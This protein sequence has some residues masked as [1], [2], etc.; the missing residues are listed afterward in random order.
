MTSKCGKDTSDTR[1]FL[2]VCHFFCC[3]H[4]STPSVIY[5]WTDAQ[6]HGIFLLNSRTHLKVMRHGHIWT[7]K[8]RCVLI[9]T[10]LF[11]NN[12]RD[13]CSG[14]IKWMHNS[15]HVKAKGKS[16][17]SAFLTVKNKL[18]SVFHAPVLLLTVSLVLSC[19]SSLDLLRIPRS[20]VKRTD[21]VAKTNFYKLVEVNNSFQKH[22]LKKC[23]F[24]CEFLLKTVQRLTGLR[25][26]AAPSYKQP[27]KLSQLQKNAIEFT[28]S[29]FPCRLK[30]NRDK[31]ATI[32]RLWKCKRAKEWPSPLTGPRN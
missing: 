4:I 26:I 1:G 12:C 29:D 20:E 17:Q 11:C 31:L 13:F 6:Q 19:Q 16:W 5:Y 23:F 9:E 22:S 30:V 15:C 10:R 8:P 24:R 25:A 2:L 21:R 7:T 27:N 14:Q 18:T 28:Y 3:Y 32:G